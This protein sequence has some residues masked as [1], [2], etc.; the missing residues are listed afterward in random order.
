MRC[1]QLATESD[2][3]VFDLDVSTPIPITLG[4]PDGSG[5]LDGVLGGRGTGSKIP[6]GIPA[7]PTGRRPAA[8]RASTDVP[9]TGCHSVADAT[10]PTGKQVTLHL[11]NKQSLG[12]PVT[13]PT[14]PCRGKAA[15]PCPQQA[16]GT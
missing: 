13:R 6:D 16:E 3:V 10:C 14:H 2:Q 12:T 15:I 8:G 9:A 11:C 5:V 4:T 1:Q 7:A